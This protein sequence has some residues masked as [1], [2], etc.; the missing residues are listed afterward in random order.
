[1]KNKRNL[2]IIFLVFSLIGYA[3]A[4]QKTAVHTSN[5]EIGITCIEVHALIS[6]KL[7]PAGCYTGDVTKEDNKFNQAATEK[8]QPN[9]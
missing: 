3:W 4:H 5:P 9:F 2:V 8:Y 1:M 6:N 7:V